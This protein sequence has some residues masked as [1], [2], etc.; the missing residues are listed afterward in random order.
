MRTNYTASADA[1]QLSP[2]PTTTPPAILRVPSKVAAP[3]DVGSH[4]PL[5]MLE[6]GSGA[7]KWTSSLEDAASGH[8]AVDITPTR[9]RAEL[10]ITN[11]GAR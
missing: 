11:W 8:S 1:V 6:A 4:R 3:P 9:R 7:S 10:P 5:R 2:K